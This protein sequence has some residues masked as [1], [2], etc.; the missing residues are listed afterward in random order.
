MQLGAGH[1]ADLRKHEVEALLHLAEGELD[2][3]L[4][5]V[6]DFP[7]PEREQLNAFQQARGQKA[8]WYWEGS[9]VYVWAATHH[10]FCD[11]G[12]VLRNPALRSR[13][14]APGKWVGFQP[15]SQGPAMDWETDL[16]VIR[17][18]HTTGRAA[19][20]ALA[21]ELAE[22][23]D[24]QGVVTVC[25]LYGDIG[26]T[27]PAL[28]AADTA[29][30]QLEYEA[31]WGTVTKLVG[32]RLPWWPDLLRRAD[33]IS[34][35]SPGA[36]VTHAELLPDEEETILRE[37]AD[38]WRRVPGAQAALTDLANSLRNQRIDS[39]NSDIRIFGKHGTS[40]DGAPLLIAAHHPADGCPLPRTDDRD[41]LA[42]GWRALAS[43][44][45]FEA[46]ESL[47]IAML[48]DPTLLPFG[49]RTEVNDNSPAARRWATQLRPCAPS[50]LHA[51]LA[52]D[53]QDVTF[54]TDYSTGIPAV[55][56]R[57][58]RQGVWVFLAPLWLPDSRARLRSVILDR[59]VWVTTT[60]NMI[61]PAPCT[62]HD[63]LWWGHGYGDRPT[64]A[65]WVISQ[66]LDDL[67]AEISLADHWRQ[68][69]KGLTELLSRPHPPGTEISR[70]A[71]ELAR[72]H[73]HEAPS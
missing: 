33:V 58:T 43:S 49:T 30:P 51:I 63:H 61:Y 64:E 53:A 14:F 67:G 21:E 20:S 25:S 42:E 73:Q 68:A 23:A 45:S 59:T 44:Q 27:G 15:T 48:R 47:N 24:A 38:L 9:A 13:T 46:Y 34:Q 1:S 5:E 50:A 70:S 71:L 26:A 8:H 2:Q 18:L 19:A 36:P 54:H 6:E 57:S 65:A 3:L 52:D 7:R 55:R 40:S 37:A 4:E 10:Q 66:L 39:I 60:D 17:I 12:A 31:Q 62:R 32:Q 11:R 22:V 28:I 16:G 35:W 56:I 29:Q 41:V 69:P 72:T